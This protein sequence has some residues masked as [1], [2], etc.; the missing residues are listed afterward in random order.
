MAIRR[1]SAQAATLTGGDLSVDVLHTE[2]S[3][4]LGD[5]T[6]L[7]GTMAL[8]GAIRAIPV[9]VLQTVG[10]LPANLTSGTQRSKLTDGTDNVEI[11]TVGAEK[12][13]KVSV[14]ATVGGGSGGTAAT[15]S[16]AYTATATQFT[17]TGGAFDDVASDALAEGEMGIVRL[18]SAR[19][20][21]VAVQNSVA[22]TG[23]FYQATQPVSIASMPSTPVTGTFWQATQP[24]SGTFYQATQP[25]SG[26]L[27]DTQLRATA[28]PVSG[29]FYQATQP[30]SIA[31][32]PSTPV[33][34]TFWQATQPVS[35]TFYQATQP[36][37]IASM[38]STPVTGTFWQATQPVSGTLTT[39][40]S[41]GVAHDA[42][43]SG[44]PVK[45]G[46]IARTAFVTA[47][48]ALDRTDSMF[49]IYGRQIT[50]PSAPR[51]LVF[52]QQTT[53]TASVT[54]TTIVT[55]GAAGKFRDIVS[56]VVTNSSAT[57]T[58]VTL[59]SNA[60]TMGIYYVPASGG[61]V[62]CPSVPLTQ[63]TAATTWTLTCGT[64]VSSIYAVAQY[65]EVA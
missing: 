49:D 47:V 15:D 54:T 63:T 1:R 10:V 22:V 52:M 33:T 24:V 19:A 2:D 61:I 58:L 65:V 37:S 12:A 51:T 41:G 5:G 40:A 28:V 9:D 35:G 16:A 44:N 62:I 20:M 6:N 23:T 7:M 55:A 13:L 45:I 43:D 25:V 8:V 38:P 50:T 31:S 60:V 30:V 56:L 27:T 32:M 29:T 14:I 3:V 4:H 46:G 36:V 39:I 48:A 42:V 26:P 64:S 18:T 17:P 53:I 57:A 21:H 34:G 11:Q 59:I